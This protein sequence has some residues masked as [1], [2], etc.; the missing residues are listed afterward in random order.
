MDPSQ[1]RKR[2][3]NLLRQ[4]SY[5]ETKQEIKAEP[6]CTLKKGLPPMWA[7]EFHDGKFKSMQ[8]KG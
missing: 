5:G 1:R 4:G 3:W 6:V 8:C 7:G 2:L